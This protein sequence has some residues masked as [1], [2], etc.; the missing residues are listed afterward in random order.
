MRCC[1]LFAAFAA[2]IALPSA[3]AAAFSVIGPA[4][5]PTTIAGVPMIP[6]PFDDRAVGT[7]VTEIPLDTNGNVLK[8]SPALDVRGIGNCPACQFQNGFTG[9]HYT[10]SG[11]TEFTMELPPGTKFFI[12][13]AAGNTFEQNFIKVTFE[14]GE[15]PPEAVAFVDD[16]EF[17]GILIE[18]MPGMGNPVKVEATLVGGE[19]DDPI[20]ADFFLGRIG[21][22]AGGDPHFKTWNGLWYDFH[23]ACDLVFL[24]NQDF[25]DGTGMDIQLRTTQRYKYSY[26]ESAALRIGKDILQVDAYGQYYVNGIGQAT[27]P[28]KLDDTYTVTYVMENDKKFK[29]TID[30][31]EGNFILIETFKDLVS[32]KMDKAGN[33]ANFGNSSGLMGDYVTGERLSRNGTTVMLDADE[34]GNEW[35]VLDTEDNLF[36]VNREPQFPTKCTM[37]GPAKESRRLGESVA[38]EAAATACDHYDGNE[39]D[40]CIYD[41]MASGD[42]ELAQAG[43]F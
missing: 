2:A 16:V 8:V 35:Q 7:D 23:G 3:H 11:V 24:K 34:F 17:T 32:I 15:M 20:I 6:A 4:D 19:L 13:Y 12:F 5:A 22:V 29:Y 40:M 31:G 10:Q 14:G 25:A 39:K 42:L 26:I 38:E 9:R 37:P 27:M 33:W 18:P 30:L 36:M 43:A 21:G 28:M 41:V 1:T